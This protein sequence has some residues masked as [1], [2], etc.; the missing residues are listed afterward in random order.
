[1]KRD[2]TII[3]NMGKIRKIRTE[4]QWPSIQ[5]L[6]LFCVWLRFSL[7]L[8]KPDKSY[9]HSVANRNCSLKCDTIW[10]CIRFRSHRYSTYTFAL[11]IGSAS[12]KCSHSLAQQVQRNFTALG[13]S[14]ASRK[15]VLTISVIVTKQIIQ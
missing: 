6:H 8:Y 4:Y 10:F 3:I 11:L 5:F 12:L 13:L 15:P 7:S 2:L 14:L 9:Q 1:M